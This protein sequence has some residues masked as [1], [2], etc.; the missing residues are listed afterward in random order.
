MQGHIVKEGKIINMKERLEQLVQNVVS[1]A[2]WRRSKAAQYPDDKRNVSSFESLDKLAKNLSAISPDDRGLV[3]YDEI[4]DRALEL[5]PDLFMTDIV[6]VETGYI[7][8]Y[9]FDYPQ[10]GDPAEFLSR[11]A[12]ECWNLVKDAEERGAEDKQ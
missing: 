11:L 2:D 7:G 1:S 10:D 4:M 12:A 8:R 6:E 5:G 9:G 3:A